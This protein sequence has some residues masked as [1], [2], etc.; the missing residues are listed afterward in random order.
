MRTP[1]NTGFS[2]LPTI[3][4]VSMVMVEIAVIGV[5]LANAFNNTRFGERL[6]AEAYAVARA[7][8]DDAILRVLRYGDCPSSPGCP[9]SY[10]LSVDER[11]ANVGI[12]SS[13]ESVTI[14]STGSA[15]LRSK[16]IEVVLGVSSSTGEVFVES[17]REI[18]L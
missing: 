16:N 12:T 6:A 7:G 13:G 11:S 4:I 9:S 2:A 5:V 18:A 14:I 10:L 1:K 17:F 15:F 8:A 3:L